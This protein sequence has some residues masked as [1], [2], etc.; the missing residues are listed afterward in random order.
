MKHIKL[1]ENF[2]FEAANTNLEMKSIFKG[3]ISELRKMGVK[4]KFENRSMDAE[5]FAKLV[6]SK[7]LYEEG[8]YQAMLFMNDETSHMKL[9]FN[10]YTV[11]KEKAKQYCDNVVNFINKT[12]S[13][14]LESEILP[15]SDVILL[16]KPKSSKNKHQTELSMD[17]NKFMGLRRTPIKDGISHLVGSGWEYVDKEMDKNNKNYQQMVLILVDDNKKIVN[18]SQGLN[19]D[20]SPNLGKLIKIAKE[21]AKKKGYEYKAISSST[22]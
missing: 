22:K 2:I 8:D 15:Y 18:I 10:P 5:G 21:F 14:K 12:Y 13:D 20:K 6:P 9:H 1:F 3:L 16:V 17:A 19:L 7:N 4:T 11:N